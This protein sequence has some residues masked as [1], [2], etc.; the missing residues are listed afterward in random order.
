MR[1]TPDWTSWIDPATQTGVKVETREIS[2]IKFMSRG[3]GALDGLGIGLL[4][5]ALVGITAGLS[6]G[7]DPPGLFSWTA[8]EKATIGGIFLGALGAL[9]GLP[10]GTAAGSSDI[11]RID[12]EISDSSTMTRK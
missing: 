12:K 5:G 9:V 2:S 3:K 10:V 11:Y 7:D 4:T 1:F 8:E 6:G